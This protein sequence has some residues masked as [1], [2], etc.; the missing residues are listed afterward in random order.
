MK[1]AYLGGTRGHQS[2]VYRPGTGWTGNNR[3]RH[4]GVQPLAPARDRRATANPVTV[5]YRRRP[6]VRTKIVILSCVAGVTGLMTLVFSGA[7]QI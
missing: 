1:A 2:A 7:L 3:R 6:G 4:V 5:A